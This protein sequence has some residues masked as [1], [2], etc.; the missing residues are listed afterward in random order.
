[1]WLCTLSRHR[2]RKRGMEIGCLA[3]Q[4]QEQSK[5][6]LRL[7]ENPLGDIPSRLSPTYLGLSS[8]AIVAAIEKGSLLATRMLNCLLV[9]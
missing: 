8:P 4:P 5:L 3:V 6:S 9:I 1:M 2:G 7:I